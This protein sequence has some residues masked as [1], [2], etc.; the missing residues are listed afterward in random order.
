[1]RHELLVVRRTIGKSVGNRNRPRP[2][3]FADRVATSYLA[4]DVRELVAVDYR[5]GELNDLAGVPIVG[6]HHDTTTGN[7][8]ARLGQ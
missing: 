1:V 7:R 3:Y 2:R 4:F 6:R 5:G 8:N